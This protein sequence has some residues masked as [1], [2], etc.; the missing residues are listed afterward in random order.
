MTTTNLHYKPILNTH[1]SVH[2][3]DERICL[4]ECL[5]PDHGVQDVHMGRQVHIQQEALPQLLQSLQAAGVL[6]LVELKQ[7]IPQL[8]LQLQELLE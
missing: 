5:V 2:I 8:G 3:C 7:D 4:C 1:C 6:R